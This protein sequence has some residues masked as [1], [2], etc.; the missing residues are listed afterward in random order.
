MKLIALFIKA[1]T[2]IVSPKI[3]YTWLKKSV[4]SIPLSRAS[5][6]DGNSV[7]RNSM[8]TARSILVVLS[9]FLSTSAPQPLPPPQGHQL[10]GDARDPEEHVL[11][12]LVVHLGYATEVHEVDDP[13]F[14]AD[15]RD[16]GR[17][18]VSGYPKNGAHKVCRQDGT[19][20][21]SHAAPYCA[22]LWESHGQ[23]SPDG[24][25][26][27]QPRRNRVAHQREVLM[28]QSEDRPPV[29]KLV[30]LC[31]VVPDVV[32]HYDVEDIGRDSED[33]ARK[34]QVSVDGVVCIPVLQ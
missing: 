7:S 9:W 34:T 11:E 21:S 25:S 32:V 6:P 30:V 24:H 8:R 33:A 15:S 17:R 31:L 28:E 2:S 29:R 14:S 10:H 12:Q 16:D 23:K 3:E 20:G 18:Q 13:P 1:R 5:R 4:P 27:R 26:H 19:L 22:V